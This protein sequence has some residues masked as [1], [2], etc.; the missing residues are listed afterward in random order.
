MGEEKT[1]ENKIKEYIELMGGWSVKFFANRMT[2]KGIPDILACIDGK[3]VAIEVKAQRGKV[4]N[5]QKYRI[6]Q[7]INSGGYAFVLYPSGFEDFKLHIRDII[8]GKADHTRIEF[9]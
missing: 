2:K 7:I 8:S 9:K 4:S 6:N 1:F 5:I 3:F